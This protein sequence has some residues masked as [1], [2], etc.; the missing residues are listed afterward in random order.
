M[1]SPRMTARVGLLSGDQAV[2][3]TEHTGDGEP[4]R[5]PVDRLVAETGIPRDQLP[6]ARVIAVLGDDGQL[7]RF[8]RK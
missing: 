4:E 7:E 2:I 5:L 3:G 6:D 1:T 8:E